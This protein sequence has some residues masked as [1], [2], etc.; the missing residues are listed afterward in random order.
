MNSFV[1]TCLI[2][3]SPFY[4]SSPLLKPL[5]TTFDSLNKSLS[6]HSINPENL[7]L[8]VI[9][10]EEGLTDEGAPF[11]RSSLHQHPN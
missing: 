6:N 9:D 10:F 8:N 4:P 3:L 1:N 7:W 5:L 11:M 2:P